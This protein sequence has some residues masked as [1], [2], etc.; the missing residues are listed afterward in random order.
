[1]AA[2]VAFWEGNGQ[3]L[4]TEPWDR[5]VASRWGQDAWTDT[6]DRRQK[7]CS[8]DQRQVETDQKYNDQ[9]KRTGK[10]LSDRRDVTTN[11]FFDLLHGV[12]SE[13]R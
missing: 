6:P 3:R 7:Q 8:E 10:V 9:R 4:G 13:F 11:G 2:S 1:M 5:Q 12:T